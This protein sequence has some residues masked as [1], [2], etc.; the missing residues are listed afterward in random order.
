M[1]RKVTE[2]TEANQIQDE[3]LF[4]VIQN[5]ENKKISASKIINRIKDL[6]KGSQIIMKDWSSD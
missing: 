6:A 4:M 3:D 5:E 2:L 1:N